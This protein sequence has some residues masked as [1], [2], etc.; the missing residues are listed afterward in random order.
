[1]V[2]TPKIVCDTCDTKHLLKVTLGREGRQYHTFPCTECEEEIEFGLE[3]LFN[4]GE[5]RYVR[6]CSKG[7]FDYF[8]AIQVHLNPDFGVGHKVVQA[9]DLI[10][11]TLSNVL[12]MQRM[13]KEFEKE[14]NEGVVKHRVNYDNFNSEAMRFYLKT[15]SLLKKGK[16]AL[17]D[18]YI[19]KNYLHFEE[20]KGEDESYYLSKLLKHII[21]EYGLEILN[22]L[23]QEKNKAG[24]RNGP[25]KSD[26]ILSD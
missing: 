25:Q 7:D 5:Y 12:E 8:E 11:A 19:D 4:G 16:Q 6:N 15:C 26:T 3:N 10:T 22:S 13:E 24:D 18:K 2:I 17:A 20:S 21:G 23:N 9:G 1:M 14:Q